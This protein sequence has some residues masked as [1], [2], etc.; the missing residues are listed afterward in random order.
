MFSQIICKAKQ[1][2]KVLT[3]NTKEGTDGRTW[4]KLKQ[5]VIAIFENLLT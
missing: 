3:A 4:R 2:L 1:S 5:I